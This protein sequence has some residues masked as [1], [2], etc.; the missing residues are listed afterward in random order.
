[1]K[2]KTM[3]NLT[4]AAVCVLAGFAVVYMILPSA[5]NAKLEASVPDGQLYTCGM[6][7]EIISEEPGLCPICN[8]KLTPKRGSGSGEGAIRIDPATKQNMG[9]VTAPVAYRNLSRTIHTFGE[10]AVPEPQD[11]KVTVKTDGWVERLFVAKDGER[12]F[13][14]QPLL[15]IYSPDL[16]AAQKEL[17][18]ALGSETN[19]TMQRLAVAARQRLQN[20]DI[21]EDQLSKLSETGEV[22]RSLII[23]SPAD[24]FVRMK[25]VV[26]GDRVMPNS[27]LYEIAGLNTLW[28]EARAYEQDLPHIETGQTARVSVAGLPGRTFEGR[29]DYVSPWLDDRGQAEIRVT[30]ANP[31]L[32]LKP[33]M[34]ANIDIES[35]LAGERLAIP[36]SAVINSG[37]RQLVFVAESQDSYSPRQVVTGMAGANDMIEIVDGL[38]AGEQVVVSG[39]F[40]LDSE[41]RLNEAV[42]LMGTHSHGNHAQMTPAEPS[43][44]A[45]P[46]DS[47]ET[48]DDPYDIHTCPMPSHYHVLNYGPGE[49]PECGMAL[50]PVGQTDNAPVYV[51]PM[52]ECKVATHEPGNCPVCNMRLMEYDPE[53]N[54]D[55]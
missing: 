18:V 53:H 14:G 15:E 52:P 16:V 22:T 28:I 54:H 11:Y 25:H 6:H 37:V 38:M 8:M 1:M 42:G 23:R 32:A 3:R 2:G 36:R 50:V 7:P 12:V 43:K 20:W 55:H 31:D 19:A 27:V 35:K 17:L 46:T 44:P 49:C 29:I 40:L 39:Q 51:C 47:V 13:K 45:E 30:L 41:T 21:S 9:L 26:E 33:S 34:Y 5:Q 24:G 10:V 48:P 4:I